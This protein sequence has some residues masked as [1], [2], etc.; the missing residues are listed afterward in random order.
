MDGGL[1]SEIFFVYRIPAFVLFHYFAPL[2]KEKKQLVA[3]KVS[4]ESHNL[5]LLNLLLFFP[6]SY[7][8]SSVFW[9][10]EVLFA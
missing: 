5:L 8:G 3:I 1:S 10:Q 2:K 6:L 9:S 4:Q 7:Q